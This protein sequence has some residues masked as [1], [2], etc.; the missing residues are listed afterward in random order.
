M[1]VGDETSSPSKSFPLLNTRIYSAQPLVLS[2]SFHSK[3]VCDCSS[4]Q[5]SAV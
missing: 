4:L 3:T 1:D 5:N 2:I